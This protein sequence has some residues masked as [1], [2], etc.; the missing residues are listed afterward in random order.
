MVG[1]VFAPEGLTPARPPPDGFLRHAFVN[2]VVVIFV[3][4]HVDAAPELGFIA[5]GPA[6][7]AAYS[8]RSAHHELDGFQVL[9][10]RQ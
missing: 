10:H 8:P 4:A 7:G 9:E 6:P 5:Y 3:D 2:P 1:G